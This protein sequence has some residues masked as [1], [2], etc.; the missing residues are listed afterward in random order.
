MSRHAAGGFGRRRDRC[1]GGFL[2]GGRHHGEDLDVS[3]GFVC[4]EPPAGTR[5]LG[6]DRAADPVRDGPARRAAPHR[7][8]DRRRRPCRPDRVT[9][10][11]WLTLEGDGTGPG[12]ALGRRHGERMD[13]RASVHVSG[14]DRLV[15]YGPDGE[16]AATTSGEEL[17]HVVTVD[18]GTWLAAAAHGG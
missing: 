10:G 18:R 16:L 12:A 14:V 15:L 5:A 1:R 9:N 4:T 11:P 6:M 7:Y 8:R 13:V 2:P 17:R 3:A